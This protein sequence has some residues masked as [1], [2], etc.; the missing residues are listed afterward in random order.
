MKSGSQSNEAL[1]LPL[2]TNTAPLG[3]A[4]VVKTGML[5]PSEAVTANSSCRPS[6]VDCAPIESSRGDWLPAS[7]TVMVTTSLS[8]ASESSAA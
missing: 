4:E 7:F 1:P 2:S 6:E 3:S 8:T 5:S